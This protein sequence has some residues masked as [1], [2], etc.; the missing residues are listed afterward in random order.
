MSIAA[1]ADT[2]RDRPTQLAA[3]GATSALDRVLAPPADLGAALR[4]EIAA[5]LAPLTAELADPVVA[6]E[7]ARR[8]RL[9]AHERMTEGHERAAILGL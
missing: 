2:S 7:L 1:R 9:T 3:G 5:S 4:E 8:S 6:R